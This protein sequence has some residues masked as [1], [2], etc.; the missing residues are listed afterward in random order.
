MP[1]LCL[2]RPSAPRWRQVLQENV[3]GI[4]GMSLD[5]ETSPIHEVRHRFSPLFLW[6]YGFFCFVGALSSFSPLAA[7]TAAPC[8]WVLAKTP[9]TLH[10]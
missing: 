6:F 5:A 8:S 9:G 1:L 3:P 4:R 7:T 10:L 2:N